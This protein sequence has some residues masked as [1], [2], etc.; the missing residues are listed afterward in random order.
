MRLT[1][2]VTQAHI[3]CGERNSPR[4]CP[5]ALAL[6]DA[7]PTGERVDGVLHDMVI[8]LDEDDWEVTVPLTA[9]AKRFVARFDYGCLV[10]PFTFHLRGVPRPS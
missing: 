8:W 7:A 9:R 1:V 3:D 6:A 4:A 5:I 2:D 10:E